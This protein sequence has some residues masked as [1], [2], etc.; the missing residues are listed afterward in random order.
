MGETGKAG[1]RL[2]IKIVLVTAIFWAVFTFVLGLHVNRGLRMVPY[3]MDGDLVVTYKLER[4]QAGDNVAYRSPQSGKTELSRIAAIGAHVVS[5]GGSN[6]LL[7]DG[8]TPEGGAAFL[9][10]PPEGES[11]TYPYTM[12][13]DGFFLLDDSREGGKDSRIFGEIT[14]KELLGKVVYL[15]RRRGF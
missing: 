15:F 6:E 11:L 5:L 13:E 14:R 3:V 8:R 12:G 4:Y 1:L 10:E 7:I 2:L 9:T